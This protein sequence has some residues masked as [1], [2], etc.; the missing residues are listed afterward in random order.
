MPG[1]LAKS[2]E[3]D[4]LKFLKARGVVR[5]TEAGIARFDGHTE[6]WTQSSVRA[7]SILEL[8][9]MVHAYELNGG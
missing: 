6:S 7:S 8:M 9:S 1:D 4:L 3:S 2:W 5:P